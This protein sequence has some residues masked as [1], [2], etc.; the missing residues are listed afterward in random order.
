M[1]TDGRIPR[2]R[3]AGK[4]G[5]HALVVLGIFDGA[6]E[7]LTGHLAWAA[8]H[9]E[10][11]HVLVLDLPAVHTYRAVGYKTHRA[12]HKARSE[13][14]RLTNRVR[15]ALHALRLAP[16]TLVGWAEL[17]ARY[18]YRVLAEQVRGAYETSP[19]FRAACQSAAATQLVRRVP[20]VL[21]SKGQVQTAVHGL[22]AELPV[23]LDGAGILGVPE[24]VRCQIAPPDLSDV[25]ATAPPELHR[26]PGQPVALGTPRPEHDR[27][28]SPSVKSAG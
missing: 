23:L 18:R 8:H 5:A 28:V 21:C 16:E 13:G 20:G 12:L 1:T 19:D 25:L 14:R 17:V 24:S 26:R 11:L 27:P 15:R 3:P 10:A 4:S 2:P 6:E 9:H 7:E 22:L